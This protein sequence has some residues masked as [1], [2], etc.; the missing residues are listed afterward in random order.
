ME[1]NRQADTTEKWHDTA[2]ARQHRRLL[3]AAIDPPRCPP[4]ISVNTS[5]PGVHLQVEDETL[6]LPCLSESE[7]TAVFK[8]TRSSPRTP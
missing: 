2:A 7:E 5:T 6:P 1:T 3:S 8:H 4:G